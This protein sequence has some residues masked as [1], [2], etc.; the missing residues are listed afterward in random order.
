M[1]SV[2][3]FSA[4]DDHDIDL[5]RAVPTARSPV[6]PLGRS[7][8]FNRTTA[9]LRGDFRFGQRLFDQRLVFGFIFMDVS[10]SGVPAFAQHPPPAITRRHRLIEHES[11]SINGATA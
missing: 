7:F 10:A 4:V 8:A 5:A 11:A 3:A 6:G 1:T 2:V 9:R